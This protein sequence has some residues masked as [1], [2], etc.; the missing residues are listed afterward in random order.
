[1]S[2]YPIFSLENSGERRKPNVVVDWTLNYADDPKLTHVDE[3]DYLFV[4]RDLSLENNVCIVPAN[5]VN[6]AFK[7]GIQG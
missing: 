1:M 3:I 6:L 7:L 5:L 2:L 4:M